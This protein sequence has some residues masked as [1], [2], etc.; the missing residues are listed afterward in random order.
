[1]YMTFRLIHKFAILRN[2]IQLEKQLTEYKLVF[3]TNISHEF[4]SVVIR[5]NFPALT[6]Q[7][8]VHLPTFVDWKKSTRNFK[9]LRVFL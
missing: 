2:R 9:T 6:E 3:F 4:R 7:A 8:I 1:M 5:V